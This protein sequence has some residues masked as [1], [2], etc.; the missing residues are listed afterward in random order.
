MTNCGRVQKVRDWSSLIA[1]SSSN[2]ISP[3]NERPS[4]T[5]Q[6]AVVQLL[7]SGR[8][9]CTGHVVWVQF[10]GTDVLKWG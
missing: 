4:V 2:T 3:F 1:Q 6:T 8:A 10:V 9:D 5:E 7:E